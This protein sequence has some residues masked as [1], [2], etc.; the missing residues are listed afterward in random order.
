[1]VGGDPD[2]HRVLLPFH[3]ILI[4]G[5]ICKKSGLIRKNPLF[6][7]QYNLENQAGLIRKS[8]RVD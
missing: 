6:P 5:I 7:G 1:M 2:T 3:I 4:A 8:T